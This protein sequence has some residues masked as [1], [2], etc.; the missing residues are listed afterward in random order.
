MRS[1]SV[2]FAFLPV[3]AFAGTVSDLIQRAGKVKGSNMSVELKTE[4]IDT[5]NEVLSQQPTEAK[6]LTSFGSTLALATE[7]Q[8]RGNVAEQVIVMMDAA[9]IDSQL[10]QDGKTITVKAQASVLAPNLK[11]L[12]ASRQFDGSCAITATTKKWK[13]GYTIACIFPWADLGMD[14]EYLQVL[15]FLGRGK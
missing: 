10:I 14:G 13:D 4:E 7:I 3:F 6:Y 2:L 12:A 8:E 5:D 11:F 1:L 15:A 9:V